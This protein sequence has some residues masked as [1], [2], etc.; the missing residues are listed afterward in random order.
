MTSINTN[1]GALRAQSNMLD[2]SKDLDQAMAR[3][4]SG[5]RINSAADDAAGSAIASK[6]DS[7]VRSLGVAI[8]NSNDAISMTQTAEGALG[9]TESILQRI[10]E[11]SVQAGNS[12]LSNSDRVMI[13]AEV[14]SLMDEINSIAE[15]TN[16]NGVK[17]LD[18][19]NQSLTFQIGINDTD[20]LEV[21][22]ENSNTKSLGLSFSEG[23]N[24]FT[25]ERVSKTNYSSTGASIAAA[26]VKINGFNAFASAFATNLSSDS[27]AAKTIATAINGNTGV[28][29][30]EANAFNTLTSDAKGTF[31]QTSTFAINSNTVA[32]A[33]SY[34][35]L[36]DNINESVSG[37]EAVLNANNT[38]TL[39]NKTGA[40]IVIAEI[41]S[42][43]GAVDSGFTV[44]TYTGMIA[45]TN[46]DG[47]NVKI[48]AGS[49]N[50]GY[51]NGTGTIADVHAL[52]FNVVDEN[53]VIKT[54]TVNGVALKDNEIL[55]ND[56]LIGK[57]AGGSAGQVAD[58]IN[59]KSAEHG[60]TA[61]A[62]NEV[63]LDVDLANIPG[64]SD[65]FAINGNAVDLTTS[66]T[67]ADIVS[68]I[69][70]KNIGDVRAS[71][72]TNGQLVLSSESG[73]DIKVENMTSASFV[74]RFTDING[75]ESFEGILSDTAVDADA[76][77]TSTNIGAAGDYTI[78]GT[79]K[80][81]T[82]LNGV[83]TITTGDTT[84]ASGMTFT[85]TGTDMDGDVQTETI[86]GP[87]VATS[88]LVVHGS[89]VFKTVTNINVDGDAGIV[90]IGIAGTGTDIDSLIETSTNIAA[91]G[92]YTL[93]GVLADSQALDAFVTITGTADESA[94][95]FVVVGTDRFGNYQREEFIGS[96]TAGGTAV[97]KK[98]F[99]TVTEIS[100]EQDA[101][102]IRAGT[103]RQLADS[104]IVA[105]TTKSGAGFYTL[106][107][108][109][110]AASRLTDYGAYVKI[111]STADNSGESVTIVGTSMLGTAIS[112]T[113]T[114]TNASDALS[115]NVFKS[116][117]AISTTA[118]TTS[119]TVF[120]AVTAYDSFVARG[121]MELSNNSGSPI[122]ISTVAEDHTTGLAAGPSTT[123]YVDDVLQK[124]GV[125]LQSGEQEVTGEDLSVGTLEQANA[126]LAM[127]DAAI[128]KV[129]SFRSSFGAV[130][131]RLD[132]SINNL[133]TLQINTS[134]AKG[135]IMDAD[136]AKETSNL[137][138]AQILSQAATSMLAQANASK[139]NLLALLQG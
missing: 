30:A 125:Q 53:G 101:G 50:N 82:D 27:D 93:T 12:T 117:T 28:H 73:Q 19:S 129:S 84:D 88:G 18:G 138:K 46:L 3:I 52:G 128:E 85:I 6:M 51:A 80:D 123:N 1:I 136:F 75:T 132:A 20:S 74:R 64:A 13:Q 96:S 7:Q 59:A 131:N 48:E 104:E 124:V 60:V 49:V 115:K 97:S 110:A 81:S 33:S 43:T 89:K 69:N 116:I 99:G 121:N 112:E 100:T 68:A 107:N 94:S 76:L 135:R 119:A 9:E 44:G 62:K 61:N 126:S 65:G 102:A 17:L 40:E 38:I 133:T 5:N 95:T 83:V 24:L 15:K 113:V 45:I 41:S 36:V 23:V 54:D 78:N 56:V 8:R 108:N 67:L 137:T 127:I 47:S 98:R 79:L 10:R 111:T 105:S 92:T 55:I 134:A 57:S 66:N 109:A 32:I 29:G 2:N 25:S 106:A 120:N 130:E 26:D 139:Q 14:N 87:A 39:S 72:N 71:A 21:A 37:V 34:Q 4:S 91:A 31:N 22:L 58:A 77:V 11:L 90:T 42:N 70:T 122:K 86:T 114:L 118:S 103:T 16:F 63:R 35:G